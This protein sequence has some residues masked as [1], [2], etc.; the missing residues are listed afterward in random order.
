MS[1]LTVNNLKK[2]IPVFTLLICFIPASSAQAFSSLELA[3]KN[4]KCLQEGSKTKIS[5]KNYI[6]TYVSEKRG[7]RWK[8]NSNKWVPADFVKW[9]NKVAFRWLNDNEFDCSYSGS[10]CFGM[11]LVVKNTCNVYAELSLFDS[12]GYNIGYTNEGFKVSK[13]DV[14][15]FIFDT[16]DDNVETGRLTEINCY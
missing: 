5:G 4:G 3:S 1:R 11:L 14:A 6:C 9:D 16:F 8:L 15:R 13:G 2:I 7:L 12:A 10:S